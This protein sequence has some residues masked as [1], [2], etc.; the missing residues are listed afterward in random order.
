M[1]KGKIERVINAQRLKIP[2]LF[3]LGITEIYHMKVILVQPPFPK[4]E[5]RI[6][7]S[8]G[9]KYLAS[10]LE[11]HGHSVEVIESNLQN[12][13]ISETVRQIL[14][15]T[16]DIIGFSLSNSGLLQ[17]TIEIVSELRLEGLSTHITLGG[18]FPSFHHVELMK[19]YKDINSIVRFEG[20]LTLLELVEKIYSPSDWN[21]IKGLTYRQGSQIFS[22]K[23]RKLIKDLDMLPFPKRDEFSS[24]PG[25]LF[26]IIAS[27]GCNHRCSF[28]SVNP[29]YKIPGGPAWRP[30]SIGNVIEEVKNLKKKWNAKIIAFMDD[31]FFGM[32][33]EGKKRAIEIARRMRRLDL[34]WSISCRSDSID[35]ELMSFLKFAGLRHVCLGIESGT[36]RMLRIFSKDAKLQQN[37]K[38]VKILQKLGIGIEYGFIMFNPYST[39]RNI[40]ENLDFINRMKMSY[41]YVVTSRLDVYKGTPIFEKLLKEGRILEENFTFDYKYEDERVSVLWMAMNRT[42]TLIKEVERGLLELKF[43]EEIDAFFGNKK[44]LSDQIKDIDQKMRSAIA[45]STKL[46]LSFVEENDEKGLQNSIRKERGNLEELS[47]ELIAQIKHIRKSHFGHASYCHR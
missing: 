2:N 28:C 21:E 8:L 17:S 14:S 33:N 5:F 1:E 3:K 4:K 27:R 39:L 19:K 16:H 41:Y 32:G 36:D 29:F 45:E 43:F 24:Y 37:I 40:S 12:L 26:A 38:A 31:N 20:E 44:V 15:K 13:S 7:E 23:Q 10:F 35:F 11:K 34:L 42:L 6:G 47:N 46:F 30:R 18:H 25:N 22:N 9:I